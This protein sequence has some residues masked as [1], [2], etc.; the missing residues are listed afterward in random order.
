MKED[1]NMIM[2]IGLFVLIALFPVGEL[3]SMAGFAAFKLLKVA[4]FV[5]GFLLL[6]SLHFVWASV[7][8]AAAHICD[9]IAEVIQ[10]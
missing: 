8:F 10:G 6:L 9:K 5:I 4:G 7:F 3:L 2:V 1:K